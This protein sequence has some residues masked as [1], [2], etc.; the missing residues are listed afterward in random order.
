MGEAL[1]ANVL[2]QEYLQEL[3]INR[4]IHPRNI[5][6]WQYNGKDCC[7][8]KSIETV[9]DRMLLASDLKLQEFYDFQIHHVCKSVVT[10]MNRGVRIDK[11]LK[12]EMNNTFSELMEGCLEKLRWVANEPEFNPNSTP[13]VKNFF[14]TLLGIK[15]LVNRK[16]KAESFGADAMLVYL[17]EYPEYRALLTLFLEYKSIKVFVRTFLSMKL[18]YDERL[19]CSYN[20]AGTKTY[21][22][23]SRK[24][25]DGNGGNLANLPSKGKIDLRYALQEIYTGEETD[26]SYS[27]IVPDGIDISTPYEG[28]LSLPNCKKMFIPDDG[29]V[30]F[31]ADYSSIDLHFVVWEADCSFLKQIIKSGQDVYSVLA[32]HYYQR[33]I[34]KKDEERQ[35]FKAICHGCVTGEHEVLTK[36]GWVAIEL[37]E[38][39][40]SIAVW[41]KDTS[42][43]H[44]EVPKGINRDFVDSWEDLVLLESSQFSQLVT[45]DHKLIYNTSDTNPNIVAKACDVPKS[46]RLPLTGQYNNSTGITKSD[47]FMRLMVALQA[48]GHILYLGKGGDITY[49]F[50]F[51]KERKI[52]RLRSI[53]TEL[54]ID[55]TETTYTRT[56]GEVDTHIEFKN[57]LLPEHKYISWD[58]LQYSET[59][60]K[61][62]LE[63]LKYWDGSINKTNGQISISTSIKEE[64]DI[65]ATVAHLLGVS[66][67]IFVGSKADKSRKTNYKITLNQ[68]NLTTLRTGKK[69]FI[70]HMGT[71]VYC[72]QT[73]TG[74][75]MVRRKGH[76]MVTGNTNYLGKA[77]TLAA[78]AGLSVPQVKKVQDWYFSECPEIRAWHRRIDNDVRTKQYTSNVFGARFWCLDFTDPMYLNKVVAAVPQSSAGILV[79]KA[80]CKLEETEKGQIQI[81]L[82]TH[83]SLSGQIRQEDTTAVERIRKYMELT[84]P[85]KDPLVIPAQIKTSRTSYGDCH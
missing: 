36:E 11:Q 65:I 18:S 76:I 72:P 38:D 32:S 46:A 58:I 51:R 33:E 42:K 55:F 23:S 22:F 21:R 57:A 28:K 79:N 41:D 24:D 27:D 26:D 15:P 75:F 52:L 68:R 20:P 4:T 67:T 83:D 17:E 37:L 2:T 6:R 81:L 82:Q 49:R 9:L 85:Y 48:D 3:A 12:E 53:L 30:F 35:I 40:I 66:A 47:A 78:K 50:Q 5:G 54:S 29:W 45:C 80:L 61:V 56:T 69:E 14:K 1:M 63:E 60:L 62:W 64:A 84:I 16:T 44:F 19:R 43:I 34:I 73:S 7:Y 25:V 10:M 77:P 8:T 70:K 31:D 59:C 74:F 71:K 39:G 13:Q